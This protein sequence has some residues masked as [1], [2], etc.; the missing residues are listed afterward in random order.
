MNH[1]EFYHF[2]LRI[3]YHL[4]CIN[5]KKRQKCSEKSSLIL[6][7]HIRS[8]TSPHLIH[9]HIQKFKN[10]LKNQKQDRYVLTLL[11]YVLFQGMIVNRLL[12]LEMAF[13]FKVD[14]NHWY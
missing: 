10:N 9:I 8:H 4:L 11:P 13:P 14:M 2:N 3:S 12:V 6:D 5:N 1:P 7:G